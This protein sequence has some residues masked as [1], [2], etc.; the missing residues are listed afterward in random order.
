MKFQT[1]TQEDVK[2]NQKKDKTKIDVLMIPPHHTHQHKAQ[3][4]VEWC[5]VYEGYPMFDSD[6]E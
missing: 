1:V 2:Y 5:H 3:I 6:S 4:V